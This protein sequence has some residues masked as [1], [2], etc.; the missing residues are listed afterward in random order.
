MT[1]RNNPYSPPIGE[2][3]LTT[4]SVSESG[5][6]FVCRRCGYELQRLKRRRH[7]WLRWAPAW[8]ASIAVTLV[9]IRPPANVIF[10]VIIV[11]AWTRAANSPIKWICPKCGLRNSVRDTSP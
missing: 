4:S 5:G 8:I 3:K 1:E 10:A 7:R 11:V 6:L 2:A 9:Y